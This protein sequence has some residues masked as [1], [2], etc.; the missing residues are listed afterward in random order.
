MGVIQPISIM[1]DNMNLFDRA[2]IAMVKNQPYR[3]LDILIRI[4]WAHL[5]PVVA[6]LKHHRV[7]GLCLFT[8]QFGSSIQASLRLCVY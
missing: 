5:H 1:E 4:H 6:G 7:D 8:S 3:P 2:C